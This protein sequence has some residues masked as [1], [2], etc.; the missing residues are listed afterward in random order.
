MWLLVACCL[1]GSPCAHAAGSGTGPDSARLVV[2]KTE[3]F[4][5]G[6]A[7]RAAPWNRAAGVT[8]PVLKAAGRAWRTEVKVLYS[9]AGLYFLFRCEDGQ[10]TATIRE[11]FGALYTE[12]VVEVFLWPDP[13]VPLYF[14]YEL[15]PLN[16]ELPILVP[17]LNGQFMGWKPW[18][19]EGKRKTRHATRVQR[20]E[21]GNDGTIRGWTAE[22][23][24]PFALLRPLVATRPGPG[25]EWRANLYRIDYDQGMATWAW[26]KT[27]GSF[28]EYQ[29]FGTLVFE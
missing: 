28:H 10:L 6:G 4:V 5:V 17:N 29:K 8:L 2:R 13:S 22:F 26:Q 11:D 7:G 9:D 18:Q 19:Y 16:H 1:A 21:Q 27:D 15:S 20:D 14:E 3:D 23:F 12:D 25:T 24:I